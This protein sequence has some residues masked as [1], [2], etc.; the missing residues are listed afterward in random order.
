[1]RKRW[2]FHLRMSGKGILFYFRPNSNSF[3]ERS[4]AVHDERAEW[5][6]LWHRLCSKTWNTP[7]MEVETLWVSTWKKH[8]RIG[9]QWHWVE[10]VRGWYDFPLFLITLVAGPNL[11]Q[12]KVSIPQNSPQNSQILKLFQVTPFTQCYLFPILICFFLIPKEIPFRKTT[13]MVFFA[14]RAEPSW[15]RKKMEFLS[16][17]SVNHVLFYFQAK[18]NSFW[19]RSRAVQDECCESTCTCHGLCSKTWDPPLYRWKLCVFPNGK[20]IS[21][22]GMIDI[23]WR[24]V[25]VN[26]KVTT[27]Q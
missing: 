10:G 3:R 7:R 8:I 18:S 24:G 26:V 16:L 4:G 22:S 12:L 9:N 14:N 1:M 17:S 19:T 20:S 15:M 25:K 2:N 13:W 27:T 23:G 21:E 11:L 5:T 6:S